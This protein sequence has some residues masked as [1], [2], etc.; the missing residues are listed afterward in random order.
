[1]ADGTTL[2]GFPPNVAA[3]LSEFLKAAQA[4]YSSDLVSVARAHSPTTGP[5]SALFQV[6]ELPAACSSGP[7]VSQRSS[8]EPF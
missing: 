1:M 3:L 8:H 6:S 5:Q 4:A 7:I 2:Q